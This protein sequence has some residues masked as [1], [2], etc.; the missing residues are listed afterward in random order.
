MKNR[1]IDWLILICV[2]IIGAMLGIGFGNDMGRQSVRRE[3]VQN[4]AAV[5]M[6]NDR[7]EPEFKWRTQL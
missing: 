4:Y 7:G 2:F 6:A 5:Y 3:A 1:D